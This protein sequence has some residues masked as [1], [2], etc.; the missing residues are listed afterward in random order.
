[1]LKPRNLATLLALSSIAVLP[2]CSWFGDHGSQSSS[3]N[4]P[5]QSYA[6][7]PNYNEMSQTT[8]LTPDMI[9]NVQQNLQQQGLYHGSVD[10]VWGPATQ[11]GVRNYQQQHNLNTTGQLDQDTLSAMNLVNPPQQPASQRYGSNDN[12]PPP[13]ANNPQQPAGGTTNHSP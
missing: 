8:E 1:M 9:R 7:A 11:A 3:A 2:A 6:A 13:P 5:A 12:P 4:P 10:G